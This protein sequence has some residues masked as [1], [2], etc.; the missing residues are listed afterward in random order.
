MSGPVKWEVMLGYEALGFG[1]ER[2][3]S[4]LT[5]PGRRREV[6]LPKMMIELVQRVKQGKIGVVFAA[7]Q[8]L[9]VEAGRF[10]TKGRPAVLAAL[11]AGAVNGASRRFRALVGVAQAERAIDP[12]STTNARGAHS[13]GRHAECK[14][15][16]P[17]AFKFKINLKTRKGL[18]TPRGCVN[19]LPEACS[20]VWIRSLRC[21]V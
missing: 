17:T 15:C 21:A 18:K 4:G 19:H 9:D 1:W 7:S 13:G 14:H 10:G 11:L 5:M 8:V 6:A 20:R 3:R 2:A 16:V 12:T